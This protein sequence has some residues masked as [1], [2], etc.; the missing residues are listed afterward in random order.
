MP[1]TA[2]FPTRTVLNSHL[3]SGCRSPR[4][5]RATLSFPARC[6]LS[7]SRCVFSLT[8]FPRCFSSH[9]IQLQTTQASRSAKDSPRR[10]WRHITVIPSLREVELGLHSVAL[11]PNPKP[12][13]PTHPGQ[14]LQCPFSDRSWQHRR[15]VRRP[16][17]PP[18]QLFK[19][20]SLLSGSE[21]P[22]KLVFLLQASDFCPSQG[23]CV[24]DD[25]K[26]VSGTFNLKFTSRKL[27]LHLGLM[28]VG[29]KTG[30]QRPGNSRGQSLTGTDPSCL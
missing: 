29:N 2:L 20:Q 15:A 27:H 30:T 24:T 9:W 25:R 3:S 1:W 6:G 16:S 21:S 28:V 5:L 14:P 18:G 11:S 26:S 23:S 7:L 12:P 13:V 10:A 17:A 22:W 8:P 4:P 19:T